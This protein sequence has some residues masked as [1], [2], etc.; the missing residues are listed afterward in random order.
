MTNFTA[1][2]TET[3]GL[4]NHPKL[5]HP[6][7]VQLSL[8][9]MQGDLT[10]LISYSKTN[11]FEKLVLKLKAETKTE[12]FLPSQPIDK[13]ATDVHGLT[14]R[15]L[16]GS[17]LSKH[18]IL[19]TDTKVILAH[20][21]AFDYRCL[22][23]PEGIESICTMKLTKKLDKQ[24]DLGVK[25]FKLVTLISHFYGEEA[26]EALT[27]AHTAEMDTVMVVLLLLKLLDYMPKVQSMEDLHVS[28]KLLTG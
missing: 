22:G 20:N 8:L 5:G 11:S 6:E 26:E 25:N 2:D 1:L 12:N 4:K 13:R 18:A 3:T 14:R 19:D 10:D 9:P 7:I 21:A 24:L 28:Y 15:N 23:K 17:R 16:V 27:H